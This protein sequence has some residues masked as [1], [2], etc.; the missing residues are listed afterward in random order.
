MTKEGGIAG[1]DSFLNTFFVLDNIHY[2]HWRLQVFKSAVQ[3]THHH[4]LHCNASFKHEQYS[5]SFSHT[6]M[7][8]KAMSESTGSSY[9]QR[10][11][12]DISRKWDTP[13]HRQLFGH[14]K[15]D[16]ISFS[17]QAWK[18]V[19]KHLGN[20][21]CVSSVSS[22][23]NSIFSSNFICTIFHIWARSCHVW[24]RKFVAT[25]YQAVTPPWPPVTLVTP[26]RVRACRGY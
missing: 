23:A 1:W 25:G 19:P 22:Y 4:T 17:T 9:P 3:C 14:W 8:P 15:H 26:R 12:P 16:P 21:T 20:Y 2:L 10:P 11:H 5:I 13:Q 6:S 7:E 24:R 18:P